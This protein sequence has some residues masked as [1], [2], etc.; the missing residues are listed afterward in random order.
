[1][2]GKYVHNKSV[3]NSLS[4]Q[5]D[6]DI[7]RLSLFKILPKMKKSI[8]IA[9]LLFVIIGE[10]RS[11]DFEGTI[12]YQISYLNL[13]DEAKAMIPDEPML[14]T[15]SIKDNKSKMESNM[16]GT[17]MTVLS[18]LSTKMMTVYSDVMGQKFK[19]SSPMEKMG[20]VEITLVPD[21][22]KSIAGYEC[23]KAL[24]S[25]GDVESL[26][27]YYTRE[28]QSDAF[29]SLNPQFGKLEGFPLEYQLQQQGF[30]MV[31]SAQE[32]KEVTLSPEIFEAPKGDYREAP[33][34][35]F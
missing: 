31:F 21:D 9:L 24:V 19:S 2:M 4:W 7:Q 11:Q 25:S 29:L 27:V 23:E 10:S 22:T 6:F 33:K 18:D 20:E 15:L 14:S 16:M 32:V 12:V 30:T 26:T 34:T 8:V 17:K 3:D 35:G 5:A 13:P 1:M 28:I